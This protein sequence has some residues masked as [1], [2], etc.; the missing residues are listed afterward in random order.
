M[1]QYIFDQ[2]NSIEFHIFCRLYIWIQGNSC[3]KKLGLSII[4]HIKCYVR[5]SVIKFDFVDP[6]EPQLPKYMPAESF[7]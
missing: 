3:G 4:I 5:N 6:S 2:K 1:I 7:S